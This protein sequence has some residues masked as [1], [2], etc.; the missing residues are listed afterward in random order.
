MTIT[1]T[2]ADDKGVANVK[3]GIQQKGTN[4][5][6]NGAGWQAQSIKVNAV[7]QTP[8]GTN[9]NWSYT[10]PTIPT[11]GYG[12]STDITDTAGK[13]ATGT[14]KPTWRNFTVTG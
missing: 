11:G 4:L 7:L 5:W 12:F 9:T 6:W 13:L 1:G 10:F 14:G 8:N 3:L 2:A